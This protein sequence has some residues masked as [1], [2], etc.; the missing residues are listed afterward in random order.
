M[1]LPFYLRPW[2][3][4]AVAAPRNII[5]HPQPKVKRKLYSKLHKLRDPDLCSFFF[6]FQLT[7]L[8]PCAII[9]TEGKGKEVLP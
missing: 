4:K 5:P 1:S 9:I 7:F 2:T 3:T 6:I 8:R